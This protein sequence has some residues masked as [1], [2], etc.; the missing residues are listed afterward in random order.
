MLTTSSKFTKEV[1]CGWLSLSP[2]GSTLSW[3]K[4][5]FSGDAESSRIKLIKIGPTKLKVAQ[6]LTQNGLSWL[7]FQFD[8]NCNSNRPKMVQGDPQWLKLPKNGSIFLTS[9]RVELSPG[10]V[11]PS[12]SHVMIHEWQNLNQSEIRWEYDVFDIL[13]VWAK[14]SNL[15]P[16]LVWCGSLWQRRQMGHSC[17]W[18][19]PP[20]KSRSHPPL[21]SLTFTVIHRKYEY[22]TKTT[23]TNRPQDIAQLL[24]KALTPENN[25][26]DC[27]SPFQ[28]LLSSEILFLL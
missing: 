1:D 8:T 25:D 23:N 10:Q 15:W 26:P 17:F 16:Q 6:I 28:V 19:S 12:S 13:D 27:S 3:V 18:S 20:T 9:P 11:F 24:G 21:D 4:Y 7:D 5:M 22:F 2:A 14:L